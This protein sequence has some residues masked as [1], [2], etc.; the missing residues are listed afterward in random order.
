MTIPGIGYYSALP[1]VS[2][3][4]EI[5]RS[6]DS[7]HLCSYVGVTPCTRSSG[8]VT[9]HGK[10]TKTWSRHLRWILTECTQYRI[11]TEP[12]SSITRFYN[13]PVKKKG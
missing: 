12:D 2:E 1:I 10:I 3:V 8:G 11:R 7:Q 4:G 9:Y 5:E 13:R 6:P